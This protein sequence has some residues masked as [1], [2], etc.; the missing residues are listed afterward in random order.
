MMSD[1][2]HAD[3]IR[4][5]MERFGSNALRFVRDR[6]NAEFLSEIRAVAKI[7]RDVSLK[8]KGVDDDNLPHAELHGLLM[9]AEVALLPYM[10]RPV[11]ILPE[12]LRDARATVAAAR[13]TLIH[14]MTERD[15][16]ESDRRRAERRSRIRP[17]TEE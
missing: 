1:K 5:L 17:V 8:L 2:S 10:E 14:Y 16:A 3:Q 12:G 7:A 9:R 4:D 6:A 15:H 11:H 13:M